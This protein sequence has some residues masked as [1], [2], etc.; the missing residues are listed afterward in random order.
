MPA[1]R[2]ASIAAR[3]LRTDRWWF[4]P[5]ITV[6]VLVLFIVYATFR[7]FQNAHYFSEPYISPFYSP[8]ITDA[9]EGNSFPELFTGADLDLPGAATS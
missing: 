9:C 1:P 6:V 7:A 8:C 2:R 5:L 3:T 4:Q